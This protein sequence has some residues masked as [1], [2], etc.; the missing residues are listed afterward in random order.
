[1][2]DVPV[3]GTVQPGFVAVRDVFAD[4][5]ARQQGTGAALAVWHAGDWVVDLWGGWADSDRTRP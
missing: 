2:S 1:M 3:E 4:V 5:L